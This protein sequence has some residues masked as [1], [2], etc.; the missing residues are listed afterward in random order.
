MTLKRKK[1]LYTRLSNRVDYCGSEYISM[2]LKM[3]GVKAKFNLRTF[4]TRSLLSLQKFNLTIPN[5]KVPLQ[6]QRTLFKLRFED[7]K[8]EFLA[9]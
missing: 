7:I 5:E 8:R 3:V 1:R 6:R 4:V 9:A 2:L